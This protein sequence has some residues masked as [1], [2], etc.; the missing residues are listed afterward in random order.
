MGS[1]ASGSS[2]WNA[3]LRPTAVG[4]QQTIELLLADYATLFSRP[5]AVRTVGAGIVASGE[6]A[7]R[8][9]VR[10]IAAGTGVLRIVD[11]DD[12]ALYGRFEVPIVDVDRIELT[13]VPEH[14]Y[15]ETTVLTSDRMLIER[16]VH[17]RLDLALP[18]GGARCPYN[19][20]IDE[21]ATSTSSSPGVVLVVHSPAAAISLSAVTPGD[22]VVDVR[23]STLSR[24]LL[25]HV[26]SS[27]DA[28]EP[29]PRPEPLF[30]SVLAPIPHNTLGAIVCFRATS[31]SVNA[32]TAN[33]AMSPDVPDAAW[34]HFSRPECAVV[35]N[36]TPRRFVLTVRTGGIERSFPVEVI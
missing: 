23:A 16:G 27:V 6:G 8:V 13:M 22:A 34:R 7:G 10:G 3:R 29:D 15:A 26:V 21:N 17:V 9:V 25:V 28:I 1:F 30:Y 24:R 4:G 33:W 5:I 11:A 19:C 20:A 2:G 18:F 32:I 35:D 31:R 36:R 12:I 14:A